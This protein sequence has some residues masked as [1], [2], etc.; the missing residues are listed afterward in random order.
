MRSTKKRIHLPKNEHPPAEIEDEPIIEAEGFTVGD[1][2][3][4]HG[5]GIGKIRRI[6][7]VGDKHRALVYWPTKPHTGEKLSNGHHDVFSPDCEQHV[8]L[9]KLAKVIPPPSRLATT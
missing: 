4:S 8:D 3:C 5:P 6:F 7:K 2:V 9:A 1:E